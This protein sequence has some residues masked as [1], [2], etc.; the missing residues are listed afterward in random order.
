MNNENEEEKKYRLIGTPS[1]DNWIAY[2]SGAICLY[3]AEFELYTDTWF[4]GEITSGLGP[5]QFFNLVPISKSLYDR[6]AVCPSAVLR[7]SC[8]IEFD[9][10]KLD[11]TDAS[12]YHG[13]QPSDEVAALASLLMGCRVYAGGE[14]R[15]FRPKGDPEGQPCSRNFKP[16]PV[17][18][19]GRRDLILPRVSGEHSLMLLKNMALYPKMTPQDAISLIRVARLY[20][21]A[22]WVVESEPHLSWIMLVSAIET[23]ANHWSSREDPPLEKLRESK[24]KLVALLE[25]VESFPD[26]PR[27]VAEQLADSLGVTKKFVEFLMNYLPSVP[28]T[29]PAVWAQIEWTEENLRKIFRQIYAARSKALH[30]GIPFPAPMCEHPYRDKTWL[31]PAEKPIGLGASAWGGKWLPPDMPLHLHVFEY[32]AQNALLK[33]WESMATK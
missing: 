3:R 12:R 25:R 16:I 31:A 29:R 8:Y 21:D 6:R 23:A 11:K 9:L 27:E 24:P 26:L 4:T 22:L 10:P 14:T 30:D 15:Y 18:S 32:I 5:Y 2:N 33:W 28:S 7:Y 13:G 1:Y 20:Q 19:L 17:L